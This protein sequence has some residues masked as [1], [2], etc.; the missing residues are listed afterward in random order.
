[1]ERYLQQIDNAVA[2]YTREVLAAGSLCKEAATDEQKQAILA[3]LDA[4]AVTAKEII[5][6]AKT[7]LLEHVTQALERIDSALAQ[8]GKY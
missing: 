7:R 1:M 5:L 2:N 8:K 6:E 3:R 4:E